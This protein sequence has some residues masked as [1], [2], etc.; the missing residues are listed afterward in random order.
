M[1][2]PA[3]DDLKAFLAIA[4]H[5]SFR[6]AARALDVSPSALSH[7]MRTLE[8]R[9]ATR[10]L[11]RTTRTVS[12]TEAGA[13]LAQRLHPAIASIA[14]ALGE[15]QE[16]SEHLTGR[17]RITAPEY[18]AQI[19]VQEVIGGF[20]ALH[21][22]VEIEL[23]IDPALADL[24][25]DGFDAGIRFRDQVP[26]DMVAVP[27]SPPSVMVA[28]ASPGYLRAHAAP[29]SPADLLEHR[30][31]RQ[32]MASG[33]VYRWEF[34]ERGHPV[35]IDPLG[36][37]TLNTSALVASAALQGLGIAFVLSHVVQ[38]HC[39]SGRLIQLLAGH[40]PPFEG[41][42]FYYAAA[43]H[44]TRAFASFVDHLRI[45][46]ASLTLQREMQPSLASKP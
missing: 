11:N 14:D 19:L 23:V 3:L 44:P 46:S 26:A 38:D 10:L 36:M 7:T 32:R 27:I 1:R 35:L 30:C 20:Q 8:A 33:A 17:I 6:R 31:I 41:Q 28:V 13:H 29:A 12:L 2:Q 34:E 15:V 24:V 45:L 9:L 37:L 39:R 16:A 22:D 42:C 21:P 40:S 4:E 43:R 25:A 18:G 5:R